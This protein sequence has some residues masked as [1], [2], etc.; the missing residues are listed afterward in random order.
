MQSPLNQVFSDGNVSVEENEKPISLL[1]GDNKSDG[2]R[3][4]HKQGQAGI[5]VIVQDWKPVKPVTSIVCKQTQQFLVS[6]DQSQKS[7]Y[8]HFTSNPLRNKK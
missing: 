1:L 8:K 6:N 3:H 2:R 4:H 7:E 5:K